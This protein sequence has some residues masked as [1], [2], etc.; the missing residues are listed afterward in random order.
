MS[1][2]AA[3]N[4]MQYILPTETFWSHP[5]DG[6]MEQLMILVNSTDLH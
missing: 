2:L 1:Q 3:A 5:R 6:I 4:T